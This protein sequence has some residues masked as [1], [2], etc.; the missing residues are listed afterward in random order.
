MKKNPQSS[1]DDLNV[2]VLKLLPEV[3]TMLSLVAI[4]LAKVETSQSVT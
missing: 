1:V 3:R 2:C 4:S